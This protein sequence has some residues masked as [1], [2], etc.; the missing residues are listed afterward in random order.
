MMR[1]A[2]IVL[3]LGLAACGGKSSAKPAEPAPAATTAGSDDAENKGIEQSD[4]TAMQCWAVCDEQGP[5]GATD[6][7][8]KSEDEKKAACTKECENAPKPAAAPAQ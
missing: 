8:S 4:V 7:A 3:C 6:W 5:K 2:S 1:L